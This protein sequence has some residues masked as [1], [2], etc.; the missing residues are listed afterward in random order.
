MI[1]KNNNYKNKNKQKSS[2]KNESPNYL[3][4]L[5]NIRNKNVQGTVHLKTP[6]TT[7]INKNNKIKM[8]NKKFN[9]IFKIIHKFNNKVL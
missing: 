9:N 4:K 2:R 8:Y 7:S 3:K 1:L 5:P 6:E